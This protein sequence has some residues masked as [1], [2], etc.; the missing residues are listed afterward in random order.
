M[1]AP[2]ASKSTHF[3]ENISNR[4]QAVPGASPVLGGLTVSSKAAG[5]RD[6]C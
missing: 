2:I 5:G 6:V 4:I 1:Y 3:L